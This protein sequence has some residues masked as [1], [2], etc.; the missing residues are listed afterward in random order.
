MPVDCVTKL[1]HRPIL[2]FELGK[3]LV[4]TGNS[5]IVTT[6]A[7]LHCNGYSRPERPLFIRSSSHMQ[8]HSFIASVNSRA[9][10]ELIRFF[11]FGC[12]ADILLSQHAIKMYTT[13]SNK[14][15][16]FIKTTYNRYHGVYGHI[17]LNSNLTQ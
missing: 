2:G 9:K 7:N 14:Q 6:E 10:T 3:K 5:F 8:Q 16:I 12:N 11:S 17:S 1:G 15:A 13:P 4:W